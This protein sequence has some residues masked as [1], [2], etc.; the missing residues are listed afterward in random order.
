MSDDTDL[1][2]GYALLSLSTAISYLTVAVAI[3][4]VVGLLGYLV[5]LRKAR[6]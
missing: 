4:A 5:A 1:V 3:L 2:V 6:P